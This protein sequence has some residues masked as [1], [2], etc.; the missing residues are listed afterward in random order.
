MRNH[1]SSSRVICG[2]MVL[3][4]CSAG[5]AIGQISGSGTIQGTVS[6]PSGAVIPQAAVTATNVA[7]G[8]QTARQTNAAGFYV[9]SPL[10]AGEYNV[11]VEAAGF[12]SLTQQHVVLEALATIPL[13]LGLKVGSASELV[14]V[15]A[16]ASTLHTEEV[17]LGASMQ[18]NVYDALPLAMGSGV[19]RDPTQFIALA[20]GVAAV[21]TQSA[22][23]SYTSFNGAQQETN[24]LYLEGIPMTFPNQQGDT[25]DL[26]LGVS[27]EAVEQ[28]QIEINGEKAQY[29]GQ[30]FHNYILKSGT[31]DFHGSAYEYF[32]NTSMDARGFFSPFVPVD[33]QNEFGGN[34][35]GPI[36]KD[37]IFFFGN[38]SGYYF[39][40]STAP[41]FISVPTLAE[42]SGNFSGV[43]NAIYDPKTT[44]CSGAICTKTQFQNNVIPSSQLSGVAKSFQSYLSPP[45][46]ANLL[47]NYLST[48]PRALH[49]N[50]TTD[51]VDFNLS[52]KNRVS[53]VFSR[54]KWQTDY[55]G[56]LTPTGTS[57]PLP[58][59]SSPGIVVE[60]P[61]IAQ[62]HYTYVI[63]PSLLNS[64]SFGLTRLWIPIF[65]T[66]ADGK[67]PQKAG[68]TGLPPYGQAA[69]GF[70]GINFSGP[71][72]PSNWAG[73]GPFNEAENNFTFQDNVQWV[74]GRHAITFGFQLQRLQDNNARPTSGTSASF[75]FS[76]NET[77]GFSP[78][79]SLLTTTGN[80]YASYLLGAVDAATIT[81]NNVVW[82]GARYHDY[83]AFVQ[84]DWKATSHLNLNL[85]LRYDIFGPSH[86]A[87]NRMSFMNPSIPNDAA[88]GRLG[89]LQYAGDG[90]F[91]CHCDVP[92][93]THYLNFEPRVG[94]AYQ[95]NSKT[96]IRSGF[97][98]AF[99]HGA[100][101]IGGNGAAAGTGQTGYNAPATYSSPATGLP[102]FY[103][104][105]GIP[106]SPPPALLTPGFGAGFTTANPTGAVSVS[107]I[108][109]DLAGKPPYYMNWSFGVQRELPGG[110]TF[111]AAYS[112]SVGHFLPRN[113]DN[114][115]W[116]NSML[117]KYLALGPL[118]GVQATPAN[119]AA[120]QA[121][122]PGIGLP[123]GNYQGTI[124]QMLKPFPQYSG[125]TY[126][127]GDLGNS[128]YHSLQLTGEHRFSKGLTFQLG[129]TFSKEIDNSIGVATNLGS[130]GGNRNPY[131][132]S[133]DKS[134]GAIDRRHI[135]HGTFV[136]QLP[137]GKG[138]SLG[139]GNAI[140]R[141]LVSGW[142]LSGIVT[143]TSGAPLA[144]TGSGCN[145]PGIVSTCMVSYNPSFNGPVRING[146]YGTGNALAPGAVAYFDKRAFV[147]PAAY[148]FGNT[149]RSAPFGLSAPHLLDEDISL[150]REIPI[151]ERVRLAI[152]ADVFNITNSVYFA[153][154]GTN[155]DSANFGQLSTAANLPRKLQLNAR[156]TF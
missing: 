88:G 29:Q 122:V 98:M 41:I 116:T 156:I 126:F 21:V 152:T 19:P 51:K 42:R 73:T 101:G 155:I 123:F 142:Q 109:P 127:S 81:Q 53:F 102:S 10:P 32:R 96:V 12:Q 49:D 6:D 130:V 63:S 8:V 50:N 33:H 100:A 80:A 39:N 2:L 43:P 68:L 148:T 48:L 129:Y 75:T 9:L 111:G 7:T 125:L 128:T 150:R 47:N 92:I 18:N 94:L 105:Q 119:I 16:T 78:T 67:Y 5:S 52:E 110:I 138:H 95:L 145:T 132:G 46:N 24:E 89:A 17:A 103:W 56:N 54:A 112:A 30:G 26:A 97:V 118:L 64:A 31:N 149:P 86:E 153:A 82:Y 135:F 79:G 146:D 69:D 144:I 1:V 113:G 121:I 104:D 106:P 60:V 74:H 55:T 115:I 13:N 99:T 14:T 58:Y 136:Y 59:T 107:Y 114:G 15:E 72:V 37:K 147:D 25:R 35:G 76:N 62:L 133:L 36:K 84:D 65:S 90:A 140:V 87:F 77:A 4:L 22:G 40:T 11:K 61:T 151:R 28:F 131:D 45:T 71:N 143:F 93:N 120:A 91:S 108:N 57:L 141:N 23:P 34:F 134:L 27:V 44:S 83:S 85:G 137:F 20:P 139:S 38:Y 117:P 154:P 124:A 3:V 66:T 70:P